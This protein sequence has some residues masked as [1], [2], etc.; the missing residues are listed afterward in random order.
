VGAPILLIGALAWPMFRYSELWGD[1]SFH[2]WYV[3]H[4]SLSIRA[5]HLPSLFLSYSGG[6]LDPLYAFYGGTLYALTGTLSLILGNSPLIAYVLAYVAGFAAAY[7]GWYWAARMA[8]AGRCAAHVPGALFITSP[9]YLTLIYGRGDWPEFMG[10]SAIPL[11]VAAGLAVARTDRPR[12]APA[13]A[14][15]G[16]GVVFCGSHNLTLLWGT[17]ILLLGGF[18]IVLCV[19]EARRAIS[20]N[21]AVA[22]RRGL[23]VAGLMI[24]ALLVSAW[25]LVPT[26][27]YE[28]HTH[29]SGAYLYWRNALQGTMPLVSAANLFTFSR[30]TDVPQAVDFALALP[31]AAIAWVLASVA[32]L[33]RSRPNGTWMRILL[34]TAG[35]T[36]GVTILMTHAGLVLALPRPYVMIQFTYRLESY[37]LLGVSGAVLA[38]LVTM[39]C[40]GRRLRL[41]MWTVSPVLVL[42][43]IGGIQQANAYP[44]GHAVI[45]YLEAND[46]GLLDYT[47]GD[48]PVVTIPE[49]LQKIDFSPTAVHH[50]RVSA[51]VRVNPGEVV[52]TNI[53]SMPELVRIA[54][55]SVVAVDPTGHDVLRIDP[56]AYTQTSAGERLGPVET[57]SVGPADSLPVKLGRLLTLLGV[58]ALMVRLS[59]IA[60]GRRRRGT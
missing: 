34:A 20:R 8:G 52:D 45:P 2:L 19:P 31:V 55:A 59:M 56:G 25:F 3:W 40:G 23:R 24:P 38:A 5:D 28:S 47:D 7:G 14:L 6:V 48:L 30:A 10:V 36:A 27:S 53:M 46:P 22:C 51:T 39:R 43:V 1:W 54:N 17:T 9:Y 44:G 41:W 21:R 42:S 18:V 50:D 26:V 37:V 35:M 4:Q 60:V 49:G 16:S 32:I 12:L 58:L 15:A 11:V 57:I 13:I 29:I 33:S